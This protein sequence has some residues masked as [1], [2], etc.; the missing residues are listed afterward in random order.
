M[1]VIN[2]KSVLLLAITRSTGSDRLN[3][4]SILASHGIHIK[5]SYLRSST[6]A[7]L[8]LRYAAFVEAVNVVTQY[9]GRDVFD[10]GFVFREL[11]A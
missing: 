4:P 6:L 3:A 10:R 1:T 2:M 9:I 5:Q 8:A 11:A 7:S